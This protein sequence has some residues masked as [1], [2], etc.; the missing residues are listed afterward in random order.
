MK[1]SG[2]HVIAAV[3]KDGREPDAA[4]W[5]GRVALCVGGEGAGLADNITDQAN[6]LVTIPMRAPVESLNVAA[7]G[8][9]LIY[10]A[11]RQRVATR[12]S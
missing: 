12:T 8:A 6:E 3:P 4:S 7:A 1:A 10:A 2:A 9:I 5:A 11:R